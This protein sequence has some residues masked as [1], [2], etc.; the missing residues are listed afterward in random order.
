MYDITPIQ[1]SSVNVYELLIFANNATNGVLLGGFMLAIF[2]VMLFRLNT[3]NEFSSA[4]LVSSFVCF[5]LSSILA[6]GKLVG[7]IYPLGFLAVLAFDGLYVY[8]TR[9]SGY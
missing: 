8:A 4:L 9:K 3:K 1:G 7:L 5:I 2:F 6:Y